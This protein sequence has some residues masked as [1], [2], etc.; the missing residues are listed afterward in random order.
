[1]PL[2][3]KQQDEL[4]KFGSLGQEK[5]GPAQVLQLPIWPAATRVAPNAVLRSSLFAASKGHR[6]YLDKQLLASQD[7]IT[8]RFTGM[9]LDQADLD[10]WEELLHLA[11]KRPL[12]TKCFFSAHGLL[13][14]LGRATGKKNHQWLESSLHRLAAGLVLLDSKTRSYFGSL[15]LGGMR[16]KDT[17]RYH[18][19]INPDLAK[20]FDPDYYTQISRADRKQLTGKPLALWLHSY[21]ASHA[22]PYPVSVT[23]LHRLSGSHTK[24]LKVF[25][26]NLKAALAE[27]YHAG[28]LKSYYIK[29]DLVHVKRR[30]TRSQQMH[31]LQ[32]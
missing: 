1:M 28:I 27:L 25:R 21:Y 6:L 9:R 19:S 31:L 26:Q 11:R 12:G 16:D 7:G 17:G 10:V 23:F 24:K 32:Q 3:Q 20:F 30:P 4:S 18:I 22:K 13:K 8:V 29:D 5:K 2:T 14:K 15:I